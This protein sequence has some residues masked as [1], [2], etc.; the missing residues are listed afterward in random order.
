[1]DNYTDFARSR[2]FLESKSAYQK[3]PAACCILNQE[4]YPPFFEAE[5]SN[6]LNTP[7]SYNSFFLKVRLRT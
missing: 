3:V 1:M 4:K 6:C 5:D 2:P 7:T